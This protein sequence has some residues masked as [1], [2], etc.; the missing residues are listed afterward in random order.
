MLLNQLIVKL[1]KIEIRKVDFKLGLNLVIDET[2]KK[3]T[4]SGNNVGKTTLLRV[5]DFCF[6]SDGKDIYTDP[7][8]RTINQPVYE[9]LFKNGIV[10]SLSLT[11]NNKSYILER[12]FNDS[13]LLKIN[14]ESFPSLKQYREKLELEIFS[15][16]NS[17][18]SIRQLMHKFIR[19]DMTSMT[20]ALKF[21]YSTTTK[22]EYEVLFL[23]LFGFTDHNLLVDRLYA[24]KELQKTEKRLKA[25]KSGNR[26]IQSSKQI[27]KIIDHNIDVTNEQ[28]KG[29]K[30]NASYER[31][32]NRLNEI[33]TQIG[34]ITNRIAN[35][36]IKHQL[37]Q[38]SLEELESNRSKI[39]P[40]AIKELYKEAKVL[41]PSLQKTFE[42]VLGF[43]NKMIDKK[44]DF[45]K[46]NL[47]ET[48]T[49]I[50]ES[51]KDLN[52]YLT[53]ES[54]LLKVITD[55]GSLSELN[56]LQN[57]LNLLYER[58]G[59]ESKLISLIESEETNCEKSRKAVELF[60]M[61]LN[62]YLF[63]FDNK[64]AIFN[65]YFADYSKKLYDEQYFLSYDK[66]GEKI[67]FKLDTLSGNVGTGK[68][69]GQITAFDFA[70]ISFLDEMKSKLPRF[71][72]HDSTED[73]HINQLSTAF[74]LANSLPGQY[75]VSI[76]R[77][78]LTSFDISF[79]NENTCLLLSEHEKFFKF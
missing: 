35:L 55:T 79:I 29:F 4:E 2:T 69:K 48:I 74:E 40:L 60:T 10:V 50:E 53:E 68:K 64:L 1:D 15:I 17:K 65:T 28:L 39:D 36:K 22:D 31:E 78:K 24:I 5:I 27:L 51:Y 34:I 59:Q 37:N 13:S 71:V 66:K 56:K 67:E 47:T 42:E 11:S 45:I 72:L 75:V 26:S 70:Y 14:N 46:R 12:G 7:E 77:D 16:K 32:V 33:K 23:F 58:R 43:H 19:K 63:D 8:F 3:N 21:L 44:I 61:K 54:K 62:E 9:Y 41:V 76:L 49:Q 25:L 73:V 52:F 38:E 57:E 6:G 20:N 18:P 30:L